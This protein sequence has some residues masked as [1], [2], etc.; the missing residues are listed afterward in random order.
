VSSTR[1]TTAG[2]A[3]TENIMEKGSK[4]WNQVPGR[5][6]SSWQRREMQVERLR[7]R[8][9]AL[10]GVGEWNVVYQVRMVEMARRTREG[11]AGWSC[12]IH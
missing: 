12:G 6:Q 2:I 4:V 11:R 7:M 9:R 5:C 1:P 3:A 8:A 10:R